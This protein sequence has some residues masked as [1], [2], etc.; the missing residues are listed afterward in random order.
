MSER[1]S[2]GET[3]AHDIIN[4]IEE[5]LLQAERAQGHMEV[6]PYRKQLFELFVMADATGFLEAGAQHDLSCDG[7]GRV[8]AQRWNLADGLAGLS[9]P[10]KMPPAQLAKMRVLWAFMR[11]WM[12]WTYAWERWHEFHQPLTPRDE[13]E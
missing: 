5:L 4:R 2:P 10:T 7:V 3:L 8:L 11:M 12:E 6:D 13:D 1:L 9:Q